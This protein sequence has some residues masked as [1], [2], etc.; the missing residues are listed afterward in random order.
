MLK[1]NIRN[2]IDHEHGIVVEW[3]YNNF[4]FIVNLIVYYI[5]LVFFNPIIPNPNPQS[6][7]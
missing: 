1:H 7:F 2:Q 6:V 5:I 4:V 3:F